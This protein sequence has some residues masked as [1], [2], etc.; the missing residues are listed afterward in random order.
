MTVGEILRNRK[1]TGFSIEVLPPAKGSSIQKI[2]NSIDMLKEFNPLFINITTHHSEPVYENSSD[3]LLK[4][5]FVRK[6]PG[7]VAVAAAL[8]KRYG[9]PTVP[10]IICNGFT[11]SETEYVLIDLNILG[12]HDLFVLRGDMDKEILVPQNECH[13]H[14]SDLIGQINDLNDGRFLEGTLNDPLET[15]FSFGVAGYPEK[16]AEAPNIDSDI[17]YLKQKVDLGA[18]YIITQLFYDNQKFFD[19]VSRCRAAGINVP[20]IPGLKPLT[21]K[22]QLSILPRVFN[23]NIPEDFVKA[24]DSCKDDEAVKQVGIEWLTQQC[25]ELMAAGVPD[26]HFYT[27]MASDSVKAVAKNIF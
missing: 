5:V 12:V 3:G 4:K 21:K 26:L 20:I 16:H 14:A 22:R 13:L 7:T 11:K 1:T 10:H 24:V 25:K 23:C 15:R 8:Q 17:R 18:E 6:R 9:I 27:L 2:Y 19:F